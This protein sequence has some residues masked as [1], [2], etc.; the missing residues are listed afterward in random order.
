MSTEKLKRLEAQAN[1]HLKKIEWMEKKHMPE[2][3]IEKERDLLADI[4]V[5]IA[6]EVHL[7]PPDDTPEEQLKK[8][9]KKVAN[10]LK[11]LSNFNKLGRALRNLF[12]Q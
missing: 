8:S 12:D 3:A 1:Q 4:D 10:D 7:N 6:L 9:I 11:T 2:R 5:E